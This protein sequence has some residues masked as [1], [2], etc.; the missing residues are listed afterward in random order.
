MNKLMSSEESAVLS[1]A[2]PNIILK[3]MLKII[4]KNQ[5]S[6]LLH[7]KMIPLGVM[8]YLQSEVMLHNW[9]VF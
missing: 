2:I 8:M 3:V 7:Y 9:Q 1:R 6:I 5:S 4:W